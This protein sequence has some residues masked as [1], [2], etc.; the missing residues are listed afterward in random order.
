MIDI[1]LWWRKIIGSGGFY[2]DSVPVVA[3]VIKWCSFLFKMI[4]FLTMVKMIFTV[5]MMMIILSM[6]VSLGKKKVT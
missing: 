2:C 3:V 5:I 1:I 4:K 6:V